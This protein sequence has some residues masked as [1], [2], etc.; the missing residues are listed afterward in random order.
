MMVSKALYV[1]Y[2][3]AFGDCRIWS[4]NALRILRYASIVL[5]NL[6]KYFL[7]GLEKGIRRKA[8]KGRK[9]RDLKSFRECSVNVNGCNRNRGIVWSSRYKSI[10]NLLTV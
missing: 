8:V 4:P 1:N 10:R 3:G 9:Y 5:D 7:W 6:L 2:K